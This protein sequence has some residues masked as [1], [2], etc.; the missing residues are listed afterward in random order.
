MEQRIQ[1]TFFIENTLFNENELEY[2]RNLGN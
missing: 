2:V 1:A